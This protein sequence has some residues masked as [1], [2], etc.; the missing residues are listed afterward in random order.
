MHAHQ[1][2]PRRRNPGPK[3]SGCSTATA[4][5]SRSPPRRQVV[6]PQISLRRQ[7]KRLSLGVYP[8]VNWKKAGAERAPRAGSS[9][10]ASTR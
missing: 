5:I 3:L 7:E 2:R 4:Y 1:H 9:P 10:L 6:A 8:E